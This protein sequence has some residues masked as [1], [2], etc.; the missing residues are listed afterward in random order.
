MQLPMS[1]DVETTA[2]GYGRV[3]HAARGSSTNWLLRG[4]QVACHSGSF[5]VEGVVAVLYVVAES[6]N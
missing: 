4:G 5:A 1:F 2:H 6:T 3:C